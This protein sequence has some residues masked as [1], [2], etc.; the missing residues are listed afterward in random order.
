M[1]N[2]GW[3]L[4]LVAWVVIPLLLVIGLPIWIISKSS[5]A[6]KYKPAPDQVDNRN[7]W[8]KHGPVIL[9]VATIV[10]VLLFIIFN[11]EKV[12]DF[13]FIFIH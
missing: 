6:A 12:K 9:I 10:I 11:S 1:G 4:I 2:F 8:Q 7:W 3:I 5:K 13:L